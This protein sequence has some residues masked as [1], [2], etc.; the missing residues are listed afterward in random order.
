MS[1]RTRNYLKIAGL[2]VGT[3]GLIATLANLLGIF[4][5]PNREA[6][7]GM[8]RS[9]GE[10][11]STAQGFSELLRDFPPPEGVATEAI[12]GLATSTD[13]RSGGN[14]VPIGP[15]VYIDANKPRGSREPILTFDELE[16]WA[17]SSGYP[18]VA[19]F[20]SVLGVMV[21]AIGVA[22]DLGAVSA[23]A[24]PGDP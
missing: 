17:A 1:E 18:W 15:L 14:V 22:G 6:M 11:P 16:A 20:I 21:I 24:R 13:A 8:I 23:S 12:A 5:H 10:I 9:R 3:L 19:W 2:V 4:S 7:V